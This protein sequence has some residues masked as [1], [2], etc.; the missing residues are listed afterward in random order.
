M[1]QAELMKWLHEA[2]ENAG[3]F[4]QREA[5]LVANEIVAWHFWSSVF[6]VVLFLIAAVALSAAAW[7]FWRSSIYQDY[8]RDWRECATFLM[9]ICLAGSAACA[10]IGGGT[11]GYEAVKAQTAPR[12][13]IIEYIRGASK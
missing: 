8:Q 13:V 11:C 3:E 6:M 5:P 2:A 9:L 1:E 10:F 12:V 4:V 7:G